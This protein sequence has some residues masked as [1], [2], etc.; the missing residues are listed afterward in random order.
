VSDDND[1]IPMGDA[2][3]LLDNEPK[4]A[5]QVSV[6]P[7][8]L[9]SSTGPDGEPTETKVLGTAPAQLIQTVGSK[10]QI[11]ALQRSKQPCTDCAHFR[12]PQPGSKD[13]AEVAAYVISLYA[14]LP[15][16]Q[17]KTLPGRNP[18]EWGVCEGSPNGMRICAYF[19][20]HCEHW[21]KG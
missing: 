15:D 13:A 4:P 14:A 18:A 12:F 6:V 21:R 11:E 5:T 17:V 7:I 20:N 16:W 9:T 3:S 2:S 8:N 1:H 19:I 10:E